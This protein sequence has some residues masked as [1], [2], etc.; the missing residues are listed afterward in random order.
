MSPCSPYLPSLCQQEPKSAPFLE[1]LN[2]LNGYGW[3]WQLYW[4]C[5]D[6]GPHLQDL[7]PDDQIFIYSNRNKVHNNCNVFESSPN[8]SPPPPPVCGK[9]VFHETGSWC[10]K[11]WRLLEKTEHLFLPSI[12]NASQWNESESLSPAFLQTVL[13]FLLQVMN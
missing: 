1:T 7:M 13:P 5:R 10:Q 6:R 8:H 4:A 3:P 9:I 2:S 11:G 12:T